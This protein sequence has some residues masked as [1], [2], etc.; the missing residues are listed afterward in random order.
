MG[1][2]VGTSGHASS[3]SARKT[4]RRLA[5]ST[6]PRSRTRALRISI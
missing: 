2:E 5:S 6:A 3:L 1:A 4:L